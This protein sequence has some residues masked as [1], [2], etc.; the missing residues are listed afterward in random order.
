MR[1]HGIKFK[2]DDSG[3]VMEETE[4]CY[5]VMGNPFNENEIDRADGIGKPFLDKERKKNVRSITVKLTSSKARAV[6][7]KARPKNYVNGIK[8]LKSSSV[9]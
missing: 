7:Y 6:F 2:E 5:N 1:I 8:I 4:K 9:R 3:D